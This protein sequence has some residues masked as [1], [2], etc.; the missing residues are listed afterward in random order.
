MDATVE[1]SKA[2]DEAVSGYFR[3]PYFEAVVDRALRAAFHESQS[4]WVDRAGAV[5]R[6]RTSHTAIDR[7]VAAGFITR[8]HL[9]DSPRFLKEEGDEAIRSGRWKPVEKTTD[10]GPQDH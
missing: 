6:W 9:N 5:A 8:Y 4:P 10:H 1:I 7:A 3:R 2:V